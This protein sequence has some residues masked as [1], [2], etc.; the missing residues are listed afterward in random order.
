MKLVAPH[1]MVGVSSSVI[2]LINVMKSIQTLS[3]W[4]REDIFGSQKDLRLDHLF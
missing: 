1:N 4:F 2:H 3:C